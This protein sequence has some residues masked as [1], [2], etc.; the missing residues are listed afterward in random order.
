[1]LR[2]DPRFQKTRRIGSSEVVSVYSLTIAVSPCL[3]V[4][5]HEKQMLRFVSPVGIMPKGV[6][7]I[8]KPLRPGLSRQFV[9]TRL[10]EMAFLRAGNG[11]ENA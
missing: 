4:A 7:G 5:A 6:R 2:G 1:V 3:A 8:P 9:A 11:P 10:P